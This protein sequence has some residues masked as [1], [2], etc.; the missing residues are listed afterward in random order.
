MEPL[1]ATARRFALG[2]TLACTAVVLGLAVTVRRHGDSR[3][4]MDAAGQRVAD[5]HI[6]GIPIIPLTAADH[7]VTLGGS[8]VFAVAVLSL[9]GVALLLRDRLSAVVAVVACPLALLATEVI[10]K[11][12]VGRREGG[13]YGFPSGHT[14]V[15]ATVITLVAL[16]AYR[17]WQ[18]RGLLVV[19]PV[20]ILIPVMGF[21]LVRINWHLFS[22]TVAGA[23]V[24]CGTVLGLAW[25]ASALVV[26]TSA[27]PTPSPPSRLG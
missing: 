22:D 19:A 13:T 20:A 12:L 14:T 5:G 4:W 16:V 3:L 23:L 8:T 15:V 27:A 25:L 18:G 26:R 10:G 21:A 1:D 9:V 11:P 17:R 7:V 6:F 24:G 2:L